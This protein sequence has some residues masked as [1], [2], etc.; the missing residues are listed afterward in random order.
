MSTNY[1]QPAP[2]FEAY[3]LSRGGKV[4]LGFDRMRGPCKLCKQKFIGNPNQLL[5]GDCA[6]TDAGRA[7]K[8]ARTRNTRRKA[9]RRQYEKRKAVA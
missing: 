1:V 8:L 3:H 7:W 4:H 6:Q 2:Q 5:C 9:A